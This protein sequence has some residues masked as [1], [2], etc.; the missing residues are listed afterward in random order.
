[1]FAT[2]ALVGFGG[3]AG[4]HLCRIAAMLG[5]QRIL[6]HPD[7]GMLS[8]LGM[9]LADV[10]RVVTRGVYQLLASSQTSRSSR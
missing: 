3:A 1:M 10:G 4:Q 8:A 7:A 6:D 5:M 9:G 2:M